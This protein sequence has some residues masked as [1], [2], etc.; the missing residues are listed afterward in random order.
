M[1]IGIGCLIALTTLGTAK[2]YTKLLP[3]NYQELQATAKRALILK[4]ASEGSSN[5]VPSSQFSLHP[6]LVV[7]KLLAG[8]NFKTSFTHDEDVMPYGRQ[9]VIHG[10]DGRLA[11][12]RYKGNPN[13]SFSGLYKAEVPGVVRFSLA[14][15]ADK[16]GFTPGL[17]LKLFVDGQ[18][19]ANIIA[20]YSVNGQGQD[21][22]IGTHTFSNIVGEPKGWFLKLAGERF[23]M[24]VTDP[25]IL[26]A[27]PAARFN[28]DGSVVSKSDLKVPYQL[29]FE[30]TSALQR[31]IVAKNG[32]GADLSQLHAGTTLYKIYANTTPG[33]PREW[34]GDLVLEG[35]FLSSQFIDEGIFFRHESDFLRPN[36]F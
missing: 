9:R 19:S 36:G 35:D 14:G 28:S 1:K 22:N 15:P 30:S 18:P 4:L 7:G 25:K 29:F 33:G 20:M 24:T 16:L 31:P 21:P 17:A 3:K 34:L 26:S 27:A 6:R 10:V 5:Y 13:S 12:V 8:F 11:A 23:N 2:D 32:K